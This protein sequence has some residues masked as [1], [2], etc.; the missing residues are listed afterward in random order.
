VLWILPLAFLLW[1]RRSYRYPR[2]PAPAV[3]AAPKP[4]PKA[5]VVGSDGQVRSP[6]VSANLAAIQSL[7]YI[8]QSPDPRLDLRGVIV[9]DRARTSP[10]LNFFFPWSIGNPGKAYLMDMDGKILW[11]WS[12]EPYLGADRSR[13]WVEHFQLLPDGSVLCG[14]QDRSILKLDRDS[15][16]VWER[17]IRAHHDI[18][19]DPGGDIYV[20]T[21]DRKVVPRIH[22]TLPVE[23]DAIT[24]LDAGGKVKKTIPILELFERSGYSWLFPRLQNLA[25]GPNPGFL[26][27]FHL[28]HVETLDG[29]LASRSRIFA[30]GNLLFSVRN[31]DTIGII[32]ARTEKIVWLWGPGNLSYQHDPQM[33]PDGDVLVFDNGVDRSQIIQLEPISQKVTWRYAPPEGFFSSIAGSVQRLANGNTLVTE[34][35]K[36]YAFEVTP[37]GEVVWKYANPENN[38]KGKRNGIIRMTRVDP[39]RLTFLP[40][41]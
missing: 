14:L 4:K 34:S 18:W 3:K 12:L 17:K 31:L 8:L 27:V 15:K 26:D 22:P 2:P 10:G 28:N 41:P 9:N 32:D 16:L 11:R 37:S 1:R 20:L 24:V 19:P 33:L 6:S 21:H 23:C 35:M 5:P 40:K 30:K 25:I 36:G 29:H 39:S 7:P 38:G 13:P